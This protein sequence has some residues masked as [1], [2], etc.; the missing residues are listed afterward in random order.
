MKTFR[1]AAISVQNTRQNK[2]FSA[3]SKKVFGKNIADPI[4][5]RICPTFLKQFLRPSFCGSGRWVPSPSALCSCCCSWKAPQPKQTRLTCAST[6][7]GEDLTSLRNSTAT[8][9][10]RGAAEG[11]AGRPPPA[12]HRCAELPCRCR[13]GC[14]GLGQAAAEARGVRG[15]GRVIERGCG[16]GL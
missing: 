2:G 1:I 13:M 10:I 8:L 12:P 5:F 3:G 7:V 16:T 15:R 14:D 4:H 6:V 9:R 11:G